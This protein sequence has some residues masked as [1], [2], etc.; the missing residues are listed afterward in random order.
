MKSLY[1]HHMPV[2]LKDSPKV[3]RTRY[4]YAAWLGNT[5]SLVVVVDN[6]I[7]IRRSPADEEDIRITNTGQSDLIYNGVPDWL[8]QGELIKTGQRFF[9]FNSNADFIHSM[10]KQTFLMLPTTIPWKSF[11]NTKYKRKSTRLVV[12]HSH[13]SACITLCKHLSLINIHFEFID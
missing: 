8:Y 11:T 7:Y 9:L 6:D 1:S 13:I 2:R 3:Q 12:S 4:Q 10:D 5:S